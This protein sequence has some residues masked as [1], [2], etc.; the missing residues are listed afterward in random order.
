[1]RSEEE[2]HVGGL[3]LS[4]K[5]ARVHLNNGLIDSLDEETISGGQFLRA[6]WILGVAC[7]CLSP[8]RFAWKL[9]DFEQVPCTGGPGYRFWNKMLV[10]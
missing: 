1:M 6:Q 2:R 10:P 7:V 9:V 8:L 3:T 4:E 5:T